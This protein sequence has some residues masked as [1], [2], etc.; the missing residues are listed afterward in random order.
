MIESSGV[1]GKINPVRCQKILLEESCTCKVVFTYLFV[2]KFVS[3][4]LYLTTQKVEGKIP[5]EK[6]VVQSHDWEKFSLAGVFKFTLL[7]SSCF[8][9]NMLS[10]LLTLEPYNK[11]FIH[12]KVMF[13]TLN[14]RDVLAMT[15]RP[16]IIIAGILLLCCRM[17]LG[18]A[19][20]RALRSESPALV[21]PGDSAVP[22]QLFDCHKT[23]LDKEISIK[24]VPR[25]LDILLNGC[26]CTSS[27]LQT[28]VSRSWLLAVFLTCL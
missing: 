18:C 13:G 8:N 2:R 21:S 15:H 20:S 9:G 11:I 23:A 6:T 10:V 28:T 17:G 12:V 26:K 27:G 4:Q 22:S 7:M 14:R 24:G 25:R 1:C 5:W 19:C 16:E 3:F